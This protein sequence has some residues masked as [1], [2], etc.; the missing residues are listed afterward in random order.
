MIEPVIRTRRAV[1]IEDET[2]LSKL[3]SSVLENLSNIPRSAARCQPAIFTTFSFT[4]ASAI[5]FVKPRC[6]A[7]L[8]FAAL[9]AAKTRHVSVCGVSGNSLPQTLSNSLK[10]T[11]EVKAIYANPSRNLSANVDPVAEAIFSVTYLMPETSG[12]FNQPTGSTTLISS[13]LPFYTSLARFVQAP[14][15]KF[16]KN[17]FNFLETPCAAGNRGHVPARSAS[18]V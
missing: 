7:R 5:R 15:G 6:A 2:Q 3:I 4:F 8:S 18:S 9:K 1:S 16:L 14:F 11:M 10:I 17:H 12:G 13:R